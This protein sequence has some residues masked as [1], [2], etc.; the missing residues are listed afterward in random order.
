MYGDWKTNYQRFL[1]LLDSAA[2]SDFLPEGKLAW[3]AQYEP[4]AGEEDSYDCHHAEH[5][6]RLA[7]HLG[8]RA[9]S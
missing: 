7:T 2:A 1:A 6:L 3:A 5:R 9:Q 8:K 4:L